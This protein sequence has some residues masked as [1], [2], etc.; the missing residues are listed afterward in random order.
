MSINTKIE[1]GT[2]SGIQATVS[3]YGHLVVGASNFSTAYAVTVAID[4]AGYNFVGPKAG[5]QFVI[6]GLL[7]Y[8][9]KGVGAN[10]AT[11][12]V[13][14]ANGP[15]TTTAD[16]TIICTEMLKQTSRDLTGLNL[17]VTAGKWVNVKTD[18]NTIF[19]SLL[20]YYVAV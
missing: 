17:V 16:R 15:T 11:V 1:D 5:F 3:P 12:D 6:T 7:L 20:G 18:D 9:N 19:A 13:Y 14:E 2:G 8:A 10:D 4:N